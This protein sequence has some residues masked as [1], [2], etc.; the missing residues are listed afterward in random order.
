MS[1]TS[2]RQKCLARPRRGGSR[3]PGSERTAQTVVDDLCIDIP[4]TSR[5]VEVLEIYLI[6]I[7]SKFLDEADAE[8]GKAASKS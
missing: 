8:S 4:V 7:I 3:A 2:I 1:K 5:E 6:V